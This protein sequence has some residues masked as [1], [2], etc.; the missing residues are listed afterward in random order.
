MEGNVGGREGGKTFFCLSSI[1]TSPGFLGATE[2]ALLSAGILTAAFPAFF[3]SSVLGSTP[4][5][6]FAAG[7]ASAFIS[8]TAFGT[9]VAVVFSSL[10][11]FFTKSRSPPPRSRGRLRAR[12]SVAAV[13]RREHVSHNFAETG[14]SHSLSARLTPGSVTGGAVYLFPVCAV[15]VV[16]WSR[17]PWQ[18]PSTPARPGAPRRPKLPSLTSLKGAASFDDESPYGG[19]DWSDTGHN[20]RFFSRGFCLNQ[21]SFFAATSKDVG[22]ASESLRP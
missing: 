19:R 9:R 18:M 13:P 6:P 12:L 11:A 4:S 1:A 2:T 5:F 3:G 15:E 16:R 7:F 20:H 22:P 8:V 10:S 14:P 17:A 21:Y